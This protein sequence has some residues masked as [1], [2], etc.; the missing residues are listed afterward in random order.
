MLLR[1]ILPGFSELVLLDSL[2]GGL[3]VKHIALQVLDLLHVGGK[4]CSELSW[5]QPVGRIEL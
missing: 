3:T 1:N 2:L 5:A 4:V